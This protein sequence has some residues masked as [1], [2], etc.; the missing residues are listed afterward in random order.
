[1]CLWGVSK[2]REDRWDGK[3]DDG[4]ERIED[5]RKE[6]DGYGVLRGC[7]GEKREVGFEMGVRSVNECDGNM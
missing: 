2:G 4:M 5:G 6:N 3:G 1:M 7:A